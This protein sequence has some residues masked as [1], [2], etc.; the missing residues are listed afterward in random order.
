M[1]GPDALDT[2]RTA[3]NMGLTLH[4]SGKNQQAA[5]ELED[6]LGRAQRVL[7]STA[8]VFVSTTVCWLPASTTDSG[9]APRAP[10]VT[11]PSLD[12]SQCLALKDKNPKGTRIFGPVARELREKN[13]MKIVSLAPEVL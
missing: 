5:D 13:F 4:Q 11:T 8:V 7:G 12:A 10:I 6:A 3:C 9:F 2:L 1:L